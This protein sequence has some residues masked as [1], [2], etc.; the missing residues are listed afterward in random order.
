MISRNGAV[1]KPCSAD[2]DLVAA[3]VSWEHA[4]PE[5]WSELFNQALEKLMVIAAWLT[6]AAG[7]ADLPQLGIENWG[8]RARSESC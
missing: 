3:L 7:E 1:G 6:T 5:D 2:N 4:A 8:L